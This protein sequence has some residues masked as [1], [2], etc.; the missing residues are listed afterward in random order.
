MNL[1]GNNIPDEARPDG[2]SNIP[3]EDA[4]LLPVYCRHSVSWSWVPDAGGYLCDEPQHYNGPAATQ[5]G[6]IDVD[7]QPT[8]AHS[9]NDAQRRA[10]LREEVE[11][12]AAAIVERVEELVRGT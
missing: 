3:A 2:G 8:F 7:H 6:A 10:L 1:P 5:V 12:Q 4:D 11:L 9:P